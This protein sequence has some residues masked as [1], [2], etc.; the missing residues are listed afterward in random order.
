MTNPTTILNHWNACS[1]NGK[2]R[3]HRRV[4]PDIERIIK[5]HLSRHWTAKDMCLAINNFAIIVQNRD[6]KS[7]GYY[8][9]GLYI[10]LSRRDKK[11]KDEYQWCCFHP[12]RFILD[13]WLTDDAIRDRRKAAKAEAAKNPYGLRLMKGIPEGSR[14]NGRRAKQIL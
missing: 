8:K 4:T 11:N 9:W 5:T 12:N 13:D 10:F 7:Y 3:T 6:Y 14:Q 1:K 2:W